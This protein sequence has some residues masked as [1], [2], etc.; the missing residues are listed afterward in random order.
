MEKNLAQK[1]REIKALNDRITSTATNLDLGLNK[2]EERNREFAIRDNASNEKITF[3]EKTILNRDKEI[4]ILKKDIEQR[5][6]QIKDFKRL[7]LQI[8]NKDKDIDHLKTI[9]EQEN[10]QNEINKRDFTQQLLN[11]DLDIEKIKEILEQIKKQLE[12]NE[13]IIHKKDSEIE[14][15]ENEFEAKTKQLNEITTKFRELESQISDEI[16]LSSKLI[17]KIEKLMHLKGFISDKEFEDLKE[18]IEKN[19]VPP[20][21]F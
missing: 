14:K 18:K 17:K 13:N 20:L 16:Q 3:L 6:N 10:K 21:N 5:N 8:I 7:E 2:A 19:Q 9:I 12:T 4:E 1:R 15:L 11:K